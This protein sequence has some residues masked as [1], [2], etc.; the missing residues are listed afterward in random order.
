MASS[1]WG[2][3]SL[4]QK[5]APGLQ[6]QQHVRAQQLLKT[7]LLQ[8]AASLVQ[9]GMSLELVLHEL[10][11]DGAPQGVA[12]AQANVGLALRAPVR[13]W[14]MALLHCNI[15]RGRCSTWSGLPDS[16]SHQGSPTYT[17]HLL[18][19]KQPKQADTSASCTC[20][21]SQP[22]TREENFTNLTAGFA[23]SKKSL[24]NHVVGFSLRLEQGELQAY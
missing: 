19:C 4:H 24:T 3:Q 10:H 14:H 5:Y 15:G 20:C 13:P 8:Q 9:C 18:V 12:L 17:K 22:K 11:V 16:H 23:V 7:D 21:I 6:M 2:I 1:N